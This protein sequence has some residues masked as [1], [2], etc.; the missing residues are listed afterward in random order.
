MGHQAS[1]RSF[2]GSGISIL[3]S[4]GDGRHEVSLGHCEGSSFQTGSVL[5][6]GCG[7]VLGALVLNVPAILPTDLGVCHRLLIQCFPLKLARI[8]SVAHY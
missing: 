1:V 3:T 6:H 8:D 2:S 5:Q 4:I 7:S